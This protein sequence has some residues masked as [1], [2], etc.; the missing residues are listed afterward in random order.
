[1]KP[2]YMLVF[3]VAALCCDSCAV[4]A[5]APT[6]RTLVASDGTFGPLGPSFGMSVATDGRTILVGNPQY[7]TPGS[8]YLFDVR[9]GAQLAKFVPPTTAING[10]F[11]EWVSVEGTKAVI[12]SQVG[13]YVFDFSNLSHIS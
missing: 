7:G 6:H 2:R 8:A 10:I 11:G 3:V 12:G 13:A 9:T 4:F 1:M 5:A